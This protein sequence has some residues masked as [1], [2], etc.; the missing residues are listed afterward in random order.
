[1]KDGDRDRWGKPTTEDLFV[2]GLVVVGATDHISFVPRGLDHLGPK[3]GCVFSKDWHK[4]GDLWRGEEWDRGSW[5][6]GMI[7]RSPTPLSLWDRSTIS[8]S[9]S[10]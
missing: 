9:T 3:D 6:L 4:E 8:I 1:M 5:V 2:E 10:G 7:V